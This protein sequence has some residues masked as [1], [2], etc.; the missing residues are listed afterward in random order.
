MA[1]DYMTLEQA[2]QRLGVSKNQF[3]ELADKS[4]LR[5]FS[6]S[7]TVRFLRQ[8][9]EEL[10]RQLGMGSEPELQPGIPGKPPS[11]DDDTFSFDVAPASGDPSSHIF[12]GSPGKKPGSDS[13]VR[14]VGQGSDIELKAQGDAA[15][16]TQAGSQKPDSD[17]DVKL[18]EDDSAIN[19]GREPAGTTG[20]SGVRLDPSSSK[21]LDSGVRLVEDRPRHPG[22]TDSGLLTE[23]L[24]LDAELRQAEKSAQPPSS[25][26][27]MSPF[28]L[29]QDDDARK[30][31]P[32]SSEFELKPGTRPQPSDSVFDSSSEQIK[33]DAEDDSSIHVS[34]SR[35]MALGDASGV[36]LHKPSDKGI[37]LEKDAGDSS[38]ETITFDL[39]VDDGDRKKPGKRKPDK[40]LDSDADSSSEFEL[41][42]E[43]DVGLA[44][45]EEDKGSKDVFKTNLGSSALKG[46]DS[47][48]ELSL[49]GSDEFAE[50]SDFE[51]ALDEDSS[52]VEGETGSEVI[53]ID[54][55]AGEAEATALRPDALEEDVGEVL[56]ASD[57]ELAVDEAAEGDYVGRRQLVAVEAPPAEWGVWGA[58]HFL[59]LIALI[60]T[61]FLLFEMIRSIGGYGKETPLAGKMFDM[62]KDVMK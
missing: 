12:S 33:L 59:T 11:S 35:E 48:G 41:T 6:G 3:L 1:Q 50:T 26:R 37:S 60:P 24:D 25:K 62:L 20:D 7:D 45:L 22:P 39:A 19:L 58:I 36:N 27:K 5:R 46:T 42:L 31:S 44:P 55:D 13:D 38:S 32:S 23:E 14:L 18:V 53:V 2:A 30:A 61:G 49:E 29:S 40:L 54:E 57:E 28:E 47:S 8:Q 56:E 17:S 21:L 16:K 43:D 52:A 15:A 51:L 34:A 10:G 9:I 4:K